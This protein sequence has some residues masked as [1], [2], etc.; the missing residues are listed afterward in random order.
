MNSSKIWIVGISLMLVSYLTYV[1]YAGYKIGQLAKRV[2]EEAHKVSCQAEC[3]ISKY[4][5]KPVMGPCEKYCKELD[6]I[7]E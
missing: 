1:L 7:K 5:G 3:K 4:K 6:N 2:N